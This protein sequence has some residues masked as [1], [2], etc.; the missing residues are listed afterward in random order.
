M[1]A[2]RRGEAADL[3]AAAAIDF[4]IEVSIQRGHVSDEDFARVRAAGFTDA[5]ILEIVGT[6]LLITFTNY[7]N[8]IANTQIDFPAAPPLAS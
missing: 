3:R 4:A 8:H 6:V 1:M 2:A 7:V 5:Q